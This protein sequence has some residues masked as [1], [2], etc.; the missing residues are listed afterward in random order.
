MSNTANIVKYQLECTC[1]IF[2]PWKGLYKGI[3]LE[4]TDCAFEMKVAC[5]GKFI[6]CLMPSTLKGFMSAQKVIHFTE[7]YFCLV[8]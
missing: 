2:K 3:L 6:R 1:F 7:A 5:D 8:F 4:K